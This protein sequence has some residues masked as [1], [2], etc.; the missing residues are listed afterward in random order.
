M[1][2]ISGIINIYKE[3]GFTSHDVVNI[4]RKSLNKIKTGHTGT[5]DPDAVGVLP[6]CIGNATKIA[7][8][9]TA[10]K[11]EYKVKLTL[12]ANT[13]TKDSSGEIIEK[14]DVAVSKSEIVKVVNNFKGEIFQKPPMFSA[15]KFGGK[16]LYTLARDGIEVDVKPRK[17]NIYEISVDDFVDYKNFEMTVVCS[18]G[19]YIRTLCEDI[20]KALG[21]GG[22]LSHLIRMKTGEFCIKDS[23]KINEFKKIL[24]QN[25]LK[26][27]L[28]PIDNVLNDFDKVYV[29]CEV[30]KLLYN[31]NKISLNFIKNKINLKKNQKVLVYD[32]NQNLIGI[33]QVF[34]DYIK[35]LTMLFKKG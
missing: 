25:K 32:E 26:D 33:Y 11:K 29:F 15:I 23:I 19:T 3:K 28:V 16:R 34:C 10:D 31:G 35:P 20:G 27:Y 14:F 9:I 7:S 13:T 12:G 21:C 24:N 6:I 22:H 5:L 17:I 2:N 18:K 4:V 30:N 8:Y 1:E